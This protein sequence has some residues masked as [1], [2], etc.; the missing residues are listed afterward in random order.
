MHRNSKQTHSLPLAD[1]KRPA[2]C[3]REQVAG[4]MLPSRRLHYIRVL[5][6]NFYD[7]SGNHINTHKINLSSVGTSCLAR[8]LYAHRMA[9]KN[10]VI[11]S[12]VYETENEV[13]E[14]ES[15]GGRAAAIA[16]AIRMTTKLTMCWPLRKSLDVNRLWQGHT[17]PGSR[18]R[19][20]L[21]DAFK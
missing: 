10:S 14:D 5:C 3:N 6:I 9:G 19:A 4:T 11:K 12:V 17:A 18:L 20:S 21:V 7:P 13:D 16:T 1:R 2:H 8:L 15:S